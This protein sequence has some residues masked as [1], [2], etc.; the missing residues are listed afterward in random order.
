MRVRSGRLEKSL[1][2]ER[3]R[4]W[5]GSGL[6]LCYSGGFELGERWSGLVVEKEHFAE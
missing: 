1:Q 5:I 2:P 3:L 6:A 4:K